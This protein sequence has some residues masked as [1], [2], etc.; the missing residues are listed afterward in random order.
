[1]NYDELIKNRRSIRD[2]KDQPLSTDVLKELIQESTLAP[3]SGNG[4]PWQFVIV[5]SGSMIKRISDESKKNLLA[6]IEADP[7]DYIKKYE[8][9]LRN[10]NFNVFY[11]APALIIIGG[12][13]GHRMLPV[14]CALFAV[15]LMNAAAARGL[16]TCWVNLGSDIQDPALR[17]ELGMGPEYRIIAPIVIGYPKSIPPAPGREKASILKI[18]EQ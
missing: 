4:Q 13:A 1:M 16:G 18:I 2:Y 7:K 17:K 5:N 15:Y 8:G 10:E 12:P 11:D 6:R 3:S 9:G 14:D